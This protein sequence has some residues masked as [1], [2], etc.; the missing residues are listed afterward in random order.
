MKR[1]LS[2]F[3]AY[4]I[5]CLA[6]PLVEIRYG[7]IWNLRTLIKENNVGGGFKTKLYY[8]YLQKYGA[9]IGLGAEIAKPPVLPHGLNGIFISHRAK[10]GENVVIFHHVTI[11]SNTIK[12]SAR[13]GSPI[14]GD[15]VYIGCGAK[16]IGNVE[17]GRNARI[18]A[19]CIVTKDIP[20]NSVAVMRGLD[21]IQKGIELDNKWVIVNEK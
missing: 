11:G 8:A 17:I 9:W 20:E 3:C 13:K 16:I 10:I 5:D 7:N 6:I 19:N 21:V 14:I 15:S 12:D 18:G 2:I 1:I 4:V